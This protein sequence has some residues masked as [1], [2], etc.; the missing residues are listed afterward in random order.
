L[1]KE[2]FRER[3]RLHSQERQRGARSEACPE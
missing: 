3:I 1:F 2:G